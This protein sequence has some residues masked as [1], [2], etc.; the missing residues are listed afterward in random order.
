MRYIEAWTTLPLCINLC[1][2]GYYRIMIACSLDYYGMISGSAHLNPKGKKA[3]WIILTNLGGFGN[4][5]KILERAT[6][7]GPATLSLG[8]W[9]STNWAMPAHRATILLSPLLC[10]DFSG[11]CWI[12][13]LRIYIKWSQM[14][15]VCAVHRDAM[16]TAIDLPDPA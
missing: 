12:E 16:V 9:C 15:L 14:A 3:R 4:Q 6:G 10:Q 13:L 8:S 2:S 11:D 7:L 1:R 5:G